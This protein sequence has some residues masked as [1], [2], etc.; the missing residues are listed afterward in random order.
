MTLSELERLH[1]YMLDWAV[2]LAATIGLAFQISFT[3]SA[4]S[5][6]VSS[7]AT[8]AVNEAVQSEIQ[9]ARDQIWRRTRQQNMRL[10]ESGKSP[11]QRWTRRSG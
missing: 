5:A 3:T 6:Q 7:V 9:S 2:R 8:E 11:R 10:N 4:A 1:K